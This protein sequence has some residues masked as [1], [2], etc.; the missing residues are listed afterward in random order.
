MVFNLALCGS[1]SIANFVANPLGRIR[2]VITQR[3]P[4]SRRNRMQDWLDK[5]TDLTAIEGDQSNI[6]DAL[7]GLAE[8]IGLGGYAYLARRCLACR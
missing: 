4:L 1:F 6:E 2:F 5:L 3:C 8:Q 7:A